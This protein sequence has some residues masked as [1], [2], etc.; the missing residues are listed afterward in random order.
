MSEGRPTVCH[1][2]AESIDTRYLKSQQSELKDLMICSNSK[3]DAGK[4]YKGDFTLIIVKLTSRSKLATYTCQECAI[5]FTCGPSAKPVA[6]KCAFCKHPNKFLKLCRYLSTEI[7]V[8][9]FAMSADKRRQIMVKLL[10]LEHVTVTNVGGE[11]SSLRLQYKKSR[12]GD[13]WKMIVSKTTVTD[14][15]MYSRP[16]GY[17]THH[18][19]CSKCHTLVCGDNIR[20]IKALFCENTKCL[21]KMCK[22]CQYEYVSRDTDNMFKCINCRRSNGMG[23]VL[24]NITN[25]IG[26]FRWE[27]GSKLMQYFLNCLIRGNKMEHGTPCYKYK[28]KWNELTMAEDKSVRCLLSLYEISTSKIVLNP[29]SRTK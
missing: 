1:I 14:I 5:T 28:L 6:F 2:C 11:D 20:H 25:I 12:K 19:R 8:E 4:F 18:E 26:L 17:E 21:Y 23:K 13:T 7:K 22:T 9:W 27:N 15:M 29:P 10:S 3:C 24:F 16:P